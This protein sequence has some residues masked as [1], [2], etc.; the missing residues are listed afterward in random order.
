M[1]WE[2]PQLALK[3]EQAP[4]LALLLALIGIALIY[5][6]PTQSD[7]KPVN[8]AQI[9]LM[10]EN[11]WVSARGTV[12][13]VTPK[14]AGYSLRLCDDSGCATV[15]VGPQAAMSFGANGQPP[16]KGAQLSIWGEVASYQNSKFIRASR[17]TGG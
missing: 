16:A 13:S 1:A 17:I 12:Q 14:P 10:G 11:Q 8:L 5:F 7:Y 4:V 6:W 15:S 2:A 3:P 9:S